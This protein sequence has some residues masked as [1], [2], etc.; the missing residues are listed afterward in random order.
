MSQNAALPLVYSCSGASSAAQL[1][2]HLA[3]KLDR[4]GVAEMSCIAGVGGDVKSLVR[5]AKSGRPIIALDGCPLQCAAQILKRHGLKADRHYDLGRLGVKKKA[6]TDFDPV[7]A[8]RLLQ[9]LFED[10]GRPGCSSP[11]R[12]VPMP[13]EELGEFA[14][15]PC[16]LAQFSEDE[17]AANTP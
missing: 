13:T 9:Q 2:N 8:D 6:H 17:D 5:L 1:S 10:L 7:E 12:S 16:Y 15:P 4:L 14:S 11:L 3:V